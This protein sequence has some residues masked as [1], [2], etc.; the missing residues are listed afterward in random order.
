MI[1]VI[2]YRIISDYFLKN[3]IKE[4]EEFILLALKNNYHEI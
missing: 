1:K 4:Y 2:W 3:R